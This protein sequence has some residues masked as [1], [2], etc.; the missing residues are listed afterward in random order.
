[1]T[2]QL[3]IDFARAEQLDLLSRARLES[4]YAGDRPETNRVRAATLRLLLRTID[5]FGRGGVAWPSIETIA[6][7]SSISV[8]QVKRG[9]AVFKSLSVLCM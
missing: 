8:R 7:R 2:Q 5:D 1:M 6:Q 9:L 3:T 4:S